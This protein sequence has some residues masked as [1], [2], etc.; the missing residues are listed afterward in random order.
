MSFTR[1]CPSVM[2][3]RKAL[4]FGGETLLPEMLM[5]TRGQRHALRLQLIECRWIPDVSA[6]TAYRRAARQRKS[7]IGLR[8]ANRTALWSCAGSR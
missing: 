7:L 1:A 8:Q 6:A 5:D 4:L 3:S 2:P